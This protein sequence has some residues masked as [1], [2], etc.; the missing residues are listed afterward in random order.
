M[1]RLVQATDVSQLRV[2]LGQPLRAGA[3]RGRARPRLDHV[4]TDLPLV[5]QFAGQEV[6]LEPLMQRHRLRA[7]R[8]EGLERS[9]YLLGRFLEVVA[10]DRERQVSLTAAW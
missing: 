8:P 6:G 1:L 9:E 2:F 7:W 5:P 3:N 10:E 4:F